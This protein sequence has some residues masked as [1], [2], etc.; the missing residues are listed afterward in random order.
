[1]HVWEGEKVKGGGGG[2]LKAFTEV[3]VCASFLE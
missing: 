2:G 3:Y 1:M